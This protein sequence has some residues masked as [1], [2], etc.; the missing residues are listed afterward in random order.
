L[1]SLLGIPVPP[2]MDGS[3]IGSAAPDRAIFSMTSARLGV[4]QSVYQNERKLIFS[5]YGQVREYDRST[6]HA[7]TTNLYDPVSPSAETRALWEILEPEIESA[8]AIIPYA[9]PVW[10]AELRD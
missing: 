7:E 2:E 1:L 3:P 10:P 8:A 4:V 6:D 9:I 5:W